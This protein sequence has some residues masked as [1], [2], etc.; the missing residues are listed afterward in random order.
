MTPIVVE[1]PS[2]VLLL[3]GREDFD[4]PRSFGDRT[5]VATGDC[6]ATGIRPRAA[7]PTTVTLVADRPARGLVELGSHVIETEGML[8]LRDVY[9]REYAN[10]GIEPG[11]VRVTA[12]GDDPAEPGELVL[13]VQP[14]P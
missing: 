1:L 6:V 9:S 4:P 11:H 13:Q 7:G 8:S 2:P 5:C 10:I 14:A 12:W 3:V